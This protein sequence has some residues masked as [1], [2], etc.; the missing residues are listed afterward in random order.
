MANNKLISPF[1]KWVGGKRQLMDSIMKS[2]PENMKNY[3]YVEPFIG[4]GAVLFHIQPKNAIIN[5]LNSELI[6]VYNVIK[7]NLDELVSDLKKH[8]NEPEYFYAIRELDRSADFEKID[9]VQRASRLI[10]LNKTCYNGLY[11]VNSAGEFNSP[12]G[13]YKNPNIVNEPVLKA[14]S[15]YLNSNNIRVLNTDYDAVLK[16]LDRNS[17]AYLDPPYHPV[18]ESA[19]FTGYVQGGWNIFDQVRLREACDDLTRRGIK[20]LLSNSASSFIKDQ[21]Q[22]YNISTVKAIRA[23]NVDAGKRGEIDEVLIRNYE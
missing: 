21:Y 4:G 5:D 17:F 11:R 14:V 9:K 6:N 12:F 3:T 8:K 15:S 2:M 1:V 19:N 7:E 16:N 10:Y 22:E 18:S 20:F 23:I 13:K